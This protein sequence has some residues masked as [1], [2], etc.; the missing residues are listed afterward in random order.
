[1]KMKYTPEDGRCQALCPGLMQSGLRGM[2]RYN[3]DD[4]LR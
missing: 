3:A 1:M 4:T 2:S